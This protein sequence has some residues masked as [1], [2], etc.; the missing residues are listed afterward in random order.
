MIPVFIHMYNFKMLIV[1]LN[2][3]EIVD[4]SRMVEFYRI[5]LKKI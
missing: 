5:L 2:N 3:A 4:L 1:C